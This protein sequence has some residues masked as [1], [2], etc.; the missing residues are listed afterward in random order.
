MKVVF[1]TKFF[2]KK[3]ISPQTI[4]NYLSNVTKDLKI[5]SDGKYSEV[6]FSFSYNAL[7]KMGVALIAISGYKIKSRIGHHIKIIEKIAEILNNKDIMVIGEAMRKKR[8]SDLY[9]GGVFIS[10]KE[11]QD[12]L[13]FVKKVL[14][15]VEKYLKTQNSLF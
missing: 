9:Q 15:D 8:N 11:S 10:E 1:E 6:T 2:E 12:Y 4:K 5:A 14:I 3:I 7:V 13:K